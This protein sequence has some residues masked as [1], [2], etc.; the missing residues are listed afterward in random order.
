LALSAR[1]FFPVNIISKE[2]GKPTWNSNTT[3]WQSQQS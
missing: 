1:I 2:S 3:K